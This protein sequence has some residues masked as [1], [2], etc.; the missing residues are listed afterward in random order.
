MG[1]RNLSYEHRRPETWAYAAVAETQTTSISL[2]IW[3]EDLACAVFNLSLDENC[4][5]GNRRGIKLM[6][7]VAC[8]PKTI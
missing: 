2:K 3:I 6:A 7:S 1:E 5:L 4:C 8:F